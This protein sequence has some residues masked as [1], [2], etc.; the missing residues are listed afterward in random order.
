[1]QQQANYRAGAFNWYILATSP[2]ADGSNGYAMWPAG[3]GNPPDLL[4]SDL[5]GTYGDQY[6]NTL[7]NAFQQ[8]RGLPAPALAG[9]DNVTAA[10]YSGLSAYAS[11]SAAVAKGGTTPAKVVIVGVKA[12]A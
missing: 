6:L 5:T 2:P 4:D 10:A 1:V 11:N 12:G 3:A 9:T 8:Y 7:T